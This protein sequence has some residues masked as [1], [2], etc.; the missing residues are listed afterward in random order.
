M[1]HIVIS[2]IF[3]FLLVTSLGYAKESQADKEVKECIRQEKEK[4]DIENHVVSKNVID[5]KIK[6][7]CE[8]DVRIKK[9]KFIPKENY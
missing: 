3:S 6:N 2:I 5:K 1:K 4:L 8:Y 7:D 9:K